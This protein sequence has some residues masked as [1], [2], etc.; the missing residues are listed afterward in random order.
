MRV[1]VQLT[2]ARGRPVEGMCAM[3]SLTTAARYYKAELAHRRK[4]GRP[5][6]GL[7]LLVNG[8]DQT[9]R[10]YLIE[11]G[12]RGAILCNGESTRW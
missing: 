10:R 4:A 5:A 7:V 2:D 9:D 8:I 3:P 1:M 12:P 6:D 11:E